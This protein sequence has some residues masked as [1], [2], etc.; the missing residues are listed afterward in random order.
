MIPLMQ[1]LMLIFDLVVKRLV[2]LNSQSVT[3]LRD[4]T[5]SGCYENICVPGFCSLI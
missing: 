2:Q 3:A 1:P 4:Q 5:S